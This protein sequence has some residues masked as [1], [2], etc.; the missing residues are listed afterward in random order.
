MK[1]GSIRQFFNNAYVS[2]VLVGILLLVA[3]SSY[4]S[5]T[6]KVDLVSG[7][8]FIVR[9][10]VPIWI[11]LALF[12]LYHVV[13]RVL[14]RNRRPAHLRYVKDEI[15]DLTIRWQWGRLANG[16]VSPVKIEP[17]CPDCDYPLSMAAN[18]VTGTCPKFGRIFENGGGRTGESSKA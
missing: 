6:S 9:F 16:M 8:L 2:G 11:L 13:S 12:A 7:F 5:L 14:A 18:R 4:V 10:A 3:A 17:I 15:Q 1:K